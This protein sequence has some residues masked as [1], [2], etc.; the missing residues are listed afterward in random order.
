MQGRTGGVRDLDREEQIHRV[1]TA[2]RSRGRTR[3]W[4]FVSDPRLGDGLDSVPASR[5][6][7]RTRAL[8]STDTSVP[9][10]PV[11][12]VDRTCTPVLPVT[13]VY[14][15]V[16][17]LFTYQQGVGGGS[18]RSTTVYREFWDPPYGR[19]RGPSN[20][21]S[22]GRS[23]GPSEGA[24][25][26]GPDRDRRQVRGATEIGTGPNPWCPLRPREK[27]T[28]EPQDRTVGV[29]SFPGPGRPQ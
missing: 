8:V 1:R 14:V 13:P 2:S 20:Y 23:G 4:T 26:S 16:R 29:L 28:T 12:Q 27:R 3:C 17:V 15:L 5:P 10:P 24:A 21:Y 25:P 6:A 11:R 7:H 22:E 18:L 19:S 9:E